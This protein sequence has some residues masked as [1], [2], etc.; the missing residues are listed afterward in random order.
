MNKLLDIELAQ[1]Y[2]SKKQQWEVMKL[3][4]CGSS[5]QHSKRKKKSDENKLSALEKKLVDIE[6]KLH[7]HPST[8]IESDD[9]LIRDLRN[10]MNGYYKQK[11]RG[12]VLRSRANFE[13][14]GEKPT[15]YYLALEKHNFNKKTIHRLETDKGEMIDDSDSILKELKKFYQQLYTSAGPRDLT[16]TE[17]IKFPTIS[18]QD[19]T[20]LDKDITPNEIALAIKSLSNDKCPGTDVLP[21]NFYKMFY[22]KIKDFLPKLYEE[23]IRDK[24]LHLSARRGI[25]S[26]LEKIDKNLLKIKSWHP[27]SMLNTDYKILAKILVTY[28]Q[29]VMK[30]I[31]HPSQTGFLKGRHIGQN[32]MRLLNLMEYCN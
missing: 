16:F 9:N 24:K 5:I 31:I 3:A 8:L 28:M 30:D 29:S 15:R 13:Y 14:H 10:E 2:Q 27:L 19:K 17:G 22:P 6:N 32:I 12:P 21:A 4:V 7:N 1:E 20:E 25:I 26:L 23:I 11:T 18:Q